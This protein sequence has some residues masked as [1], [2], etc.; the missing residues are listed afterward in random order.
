MWIGEWVLFCHTS[1]FRKW[2]RDG[3]RASRAAQERLTGLGCC[4]L[5]VVSLLLR[6]PSTI[7]TPFPIE[8]SKWHLQTR[9]LDRQAKRTTYVVV[10]RWHMR[11]TG[12]MMAGRLG[13]REG[14]QGEWGKKDAGM[15]LSGGVKHWDKWKLRT[16]LERVV[17]TSNRTARLEL[18]KALD[19]G[20]NWKWFQFGLEGNRQIDLWS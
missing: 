19:A 13:I 15:V 1:D 3:K 9:S 10:K 2:Q 17:F 7:T 11:S 16:A 20:K 8:L 12:V 14:W 18:T 5:L 6:P 4:A